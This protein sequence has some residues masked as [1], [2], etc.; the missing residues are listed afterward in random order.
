MID[1]SR[2]TVVEAECYTPIPR[3]RYSPKTSEVS[4]ERMQ[5]KAR[6]VHIIR[7]TLL[8]GLRAD[9]RQ[10][11]FIP[12]ALPY[13]PSSVSIAQLGGAAQ[14]NSHRV[15]QPAVR[16]GYSIVGQRVSVFSASHVLIRD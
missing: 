5:P 8:N 1:I 16:A 12:I 9:F 14:L 15:H 13:P 3:D 11:R 2:M 10:S 6:N 7:R 4:L